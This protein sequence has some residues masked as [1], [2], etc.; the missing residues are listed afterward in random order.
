MIWTRS[1][2]FAGGTYLALLLALSL[3]AAR[4]RE[5]PS[6]FLNASGSLPLWVCIAASIAANCGSLDV[7]AM[8]ALGAQ[9]GMIACHFYWIGAVPALIA[10][11]FWLMPAYARRGFPTVLDFI[12]HYYGE[13]TRLAVALCMA[14][15]MLLL[16]GVCLSAVAQTMMVFAGWRFAT[17]ALA[18]AVL[19]LLYTWI[20]GLRGTIYTELL[21]FTVVLAAVT[22]LLF[23]ILHD[24]GGPSKLFAQFPADHRF[25]W[26][27]LPVFAPGA[28]MDVA[29]VVCGLGVVLGFGYWSTD[30]VQMQRMLAVR[31]RADAP[32]IPLSL[33]GARI[34]FAFLIVWPGIAAPLVLSR[35]PASNWNATLPALMEHYYNPFW[36]AIGV[37]GLVASLISTY[38]RNVSAFSAAWMQGV[39]HPSV[40]RELTNDRLVWMARL[41][42]AA[43]VLLSIGAAYWALSY[44]SLMESIQTVLSIFNAPLFA[45][46]ALV[47][48]APR[49][50]ANGGMAGL[51]AGIGSA[52]AH[53]L[54]V[55]AGLLHYGSRM[56][57][58]F[59][60]AILSFC[61]T[62]MVTMMA[63]A[64][65]AAR[66]EA[67][68]SSEHGDRLRLSFSIP[69]L[70]WAVIVGGCCLLINILLR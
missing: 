19:V 9:Y 44:Q 3:L 12:E 38:A 24:F 30:F 46:V 60:V 43:V 59:Y 11:A 32:L 17:G 25:A 52:L 39:Y 8:T 14:A 6:Q 26:R 35:A 36:M 54:M 15:M 27:T 45:L 7:I 2:I 56:S 18:T 23:L 63:S 21:H 20:G 67:A 47:A 10:V 1:S 29:G 62:A 22:P 40:R 55:Q 13:R 65:R 37:M 16:C 31:N 51:L 48:V 42:N 53:E 61:V 57:A 50:S 68:P 49:L 34:A 70:A 66:S 4:R 41:S 69:V 28:T 5:T 33:A 58:A 64:L